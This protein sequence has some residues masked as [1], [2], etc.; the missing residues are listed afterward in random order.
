MSASNKGIVII[1]AGECGVSAA[2]T[3]RE[4]GYAGII[5]LIGDETHLP[6]ERPPLS[7]TVPVVP[8]PIREEQSYKDADIDLKFGTIVLGIDPTTGTVHLADGNGIKYSKLLIATG[9]RPRVFA[10]TEKARTLR[11]LDDATEILNAIKSQIKLVI[12]GAGF[13]GLELAATAR[14][15][16]ANVTVLEAGE[17]AMARGVPASVSEYVSKRHSDEGVELVFNSPVTDITDSEV[18][19]SNGVSYP[20]DLV[21]A[22]TGSEPNVELAANCDLEVNNGVVVD[23][24]YKTSNPDIFAAGDC[25]SFPLNGQMIRLESWRAA[26]EQGRSAALNMLGLQEDHQTVSWLWSD[27][28]D[29]TIQVAGIPPERG[30][31]II[32]EPAKANGFIEC[33]LDEDGHIQYAAGVGIG[34]AIAKDIRLLEMMIVKGIKPDPSQLSDQNTNLKRMLKAS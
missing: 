24:H 4:Q 14:T 16:G 12:V 20:Y 27:Q 26:Q 33:V 3:L 19:S 22:G 9:S 5:T 10:G 7:K 28:Y 30:R 17:R 11:S 6:Y 18:H 25:C 32:R 8:K 13:I 15:L 1:G 29:L 21:V 2:F 23:D 31:S 34:N